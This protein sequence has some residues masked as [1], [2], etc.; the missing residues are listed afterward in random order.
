MDWLSYGTLGFAPGLFWLWFIVR[1]DRFAPEPRWLVLRVFLLGCAAPV[2]VLLARPL[3][4]RLLLPQQ[5][6][7]RRLLLDAFV[8]T[9]LCEELVKA[10]ALSAGI[11]FHREFDEPLDGIVY[12]AAA[13]LGF[14]SVENV[15]FLFADRE[16][17]LAVARGCTS[18]LIH[19]AC[20]GTLGLL[21]ARG[22]I[23][24][25]HRDTAIAIAGLLL[26]V[27]VHGSYDACLLAG[28]RAGRLGLLVI[29]PAVLVAFAWLLRWAMR[30]SAERVARASS[31]VT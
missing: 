15:F 27:L 6:T 25:D 23:S 2:V 12:G 18:T 17:F 1:K 20:T 19:L 29:T 31:P 14:A 7:T 10:A 4:E 8:V 5:L 30:D 9:A 3:V 13:A 21:L 16:P 24:R 26:V 11:L 28:P 22:R